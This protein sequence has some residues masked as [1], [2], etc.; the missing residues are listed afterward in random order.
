M[1]TLLCLKTY[2]FF[3]FQLLMIYAICGIV[4]PLSVNDLSNSI[5]DGS[6]IRVAYQARGCLFDDDFTLLLL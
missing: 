4:G 3:F 5:R 1:L 2:T 6:R